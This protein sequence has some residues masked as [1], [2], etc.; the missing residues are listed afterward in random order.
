[1]AHRYVGLAIP[2]NWKSKRRID[3]AIPRHIVFDLSVNLPG[4]GDK[5]D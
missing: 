5:T 1:M 3:E 2:L 4:R